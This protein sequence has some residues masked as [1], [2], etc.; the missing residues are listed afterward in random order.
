MDNQTLLLLVV[1]AVVALYFLYPTLCEQGG[2]TKKQENYDETTSGI[3]DDV[4]PRLYQPHLTDAVDNSPFVG[5]PDE[6]L[7][8]WAMNTLQYGEMDILDDGMRGNA[9]LNFNMCSKSCCSPQY[10]PPFSM[11]VDPLVC[12]S[13]QEFVPSGYSCNNGWQ[14]SGCLCMTK[15]QALFLNRRGNNS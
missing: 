9:G 11:P 12:K 14:D 8:P 4:N 10:P 2:Y 6:L 5:L 3:L 15:N 13:G 1:V 7:A